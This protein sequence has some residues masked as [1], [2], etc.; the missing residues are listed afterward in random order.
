M[1]TARTSIQ[2]SAP[3]M[4]IYFLLFWSSLLIVS[5]ASF[6]WGERP[7][8]AVSVMFLGA[9]IATSLVRPAASIS[10][11]DVQIGVLLIDGLL[12]AGLVLV[13]VRADRWWPICAT[14]LQL[15]TML[16]HLGK[17][18]NP[19]LWPYGYQLMAVWASWPMVA[20]L[21]VGVL[22]CRIRTARR[23]GT[24]PG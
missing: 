24:S 19:R 8:R 21:A 2:G 20:V 15:L 14:A 10:Y 13:T 22:R 4:S 17:A 23:G 16:S 7:E 12:L 1:R 6:R 3:P 9:A 5:L 18:V 11:R